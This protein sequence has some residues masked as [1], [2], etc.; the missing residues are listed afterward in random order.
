MDDDN[1]IGLLL[2]LELIFSASLAVDF[3][4]GFDISFPKDASFSFN[5]I[6]GEMVDTN[7]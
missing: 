7:L 6:K 2:S 1:K 3:T 5:T 4:A